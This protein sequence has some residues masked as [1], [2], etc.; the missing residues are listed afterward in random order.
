MAAGTC[1]PGQTP[2]AVSNF[3]GVKGGSSS[4]FNWNLSWPLAG[5]QYELFRS[6]D[7]INFSSIYTTTGITDS[8]INF[9]YTDNTLPASG[10]AYYYYLAASAAGYPT[11]ITDTLKI[12]NEAQIAVNASA[13]LNLCGFS[14]AVGT[15]SAAQTYTV[16]ASNLTSNLVITPPVNFEVSANNSTWFTNAA[17]LSITP[18][19][20]A[21]PLTTIYIRLNAATAGNYSGNVINASTGAVTVPVVVSGTASAPPTSVLLQQWPLTINNNDSGAVRS[22]AVTASAATLNNLFTSDGSAASVSIPSFSGQYGQALGA[23]AAGNNW[24]IVGGTL[25]RNYY[26]Q[27]TITAAPGNTVRVDSITFLSDFYLTVSGIKMA[28]VYSKTGFTTSDSTEFL[29]GVT[30]N[31]T[32]LVLST[33]GNFTKSFPILRNDAG[34]INYYA[35]SLNGISG[36]TLNPGESVTIRL[37]WACGSTGTPRFA[38]IKNVRVMGVSNSTVPV[39]L[40]SFTAG[41]ER[42]KLMLRWATTYEQNLDRFEIE[43]STNGTSFSTLASV[44]AK[45]AAAGHTYSTEDI[46]PLYLDAYYRLKMVDK[47]RT[48][49]YSSTLLVKAALAN[50]LR[51]LPNPA[52]SYSSINMPVSDVYQVRLADVTDRTVQAQ[53]FTGRNLRID[54]RKLLP[55]TYYLTIH[56]SKGDY[57]TEPI[58]IN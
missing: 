6:S 49:K 43:R 4:A 41:Y 12:S 24:S 17:P 15:P 45:N 25:K 14:Q 48:V 44:A 46:S 1:T 9:S 27:F 42:K 13:A 52:S 19:S 47:D 36:V 58:I 11:H 37:Y 8:V 39:N 7:N 56:N 57:A 38:F 51:I 18:G 40:V 55:G 2:L 26:E 53:S 22:A 29:N 31:G 21:V 23:N 10:T 5:V 34:A 16:S 50:W 35:L 32:S 3:N 20:G 28:A 54:L 30:G 33:S